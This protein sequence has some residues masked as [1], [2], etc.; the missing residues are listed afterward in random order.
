MEFKTQKNAGK[1]HSYLIQIGS[2]LYS[3]NLFKKISYMTI[4]SFFYFCHPNKGSQ[5]KFNQTI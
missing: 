1:F 5:I 3:P 2:K 4:L